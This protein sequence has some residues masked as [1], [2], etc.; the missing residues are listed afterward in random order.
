MHPVVTVVIRRSH[1][2]ACLQTY[3]PK[4]TDQGMMVLIASSD[5]HVA[6][7]APYG[8]R[9]PLYTP[10]PVACGIPTDDDPILIDISASIT[11]NGMSGRLAAQGRQMDYVA[12]LDAEKVPVCVGFSGLAFRSMLGMPRLVPQT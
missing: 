5:P 6:T 9:K 11:T 8:G 10:D 3:L 4:A 1:H 12:Y 7:V 2:I